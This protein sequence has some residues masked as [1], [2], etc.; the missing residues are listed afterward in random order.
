VS[1][2]TPTICKEKPTT[3]PIAGSD[4]VILKVL[5]LL[6]IVGGALAVIYIIVSALSLISSSGDASKLKETRDTIIYASAGLI[7]ILIAPEIVKYFL[8]LVA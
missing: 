2:D 7:V 3:D 5:G 8:K 1:T 6:R 4:G